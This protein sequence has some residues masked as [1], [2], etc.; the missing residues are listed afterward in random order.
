MPGWQYVLDMPTSMRIGEAFSNPDDPQPRVETPTQGSCRSALNYD[1][2]SE[3]PRDTSASPPPPP[4]P[5]PP[6][7][8]VLAAARRNLHFGQQAV[9]PH[10]QKQSNP[11]PTNKPRTPGV[12]LS[13]VLLASASQG[14]FL[15]LVFETTNDQ[16]RLV[17]KRLVVSNRRNDLKSQL[18]LYAA[19]HRAFVDTIIQALPEIEKS[20]V[21]AQVKSNLT[22]AWT[23]SQQL[24]NTIEKWQQLL[25]GDENEDLLKLEG[26]CL[27]NQQELQRH[28]MDFFPQPL[29][30]QDAPTSA[31]TPD[32]LVP[33][34]LVPAPS[35]PSS[36]TSS[37]SGS[38]VTI[39]QQYLKTIGTL[40]LL[41]DRIFNLGSD[42][43]LQKQRREG[44]RAAGRALV[45]SDKD[46]YARFRQRRLKIVN[47]YWATKREM[48]HTY[49]S[50]LDD[51]MAVQE[52]N[53]PPNL[54]EMFETEDSDYIQPRFKDDPYGLSEAS[55]N[56]TRWAQHVQKASLP[57]NIHS[58]GSKIATKDV[59]DTLQ[60]V[61]YQQTQ[62]STDLNWA[63]AS[64]GT[65]RTPQQPLSF[66]GDRPISGRRY[67][68]PMLLEKTDRDE[69][70]SALD[71]RDGITRKLERKKRELK[72]A[73]RRAS[74]DC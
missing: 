36:V 59:E 30:D 54:D 63:T 7:P 73:L 9:K 10:G 46:F 15:N 43:Q 55:M 72:L 2:M 39:M 66:L 47:D 12:P 28:V 74:S 1:Q 49:Q 38:T 27:V 22:Q 44:Y 5:P 33:N 53:L 42:L 17:Q 61:R 21:S 62:A 3:P 70:T 37:S 68:A 40:N 24:S 16:E 58:I 45:P 23:K 8:E 35:P 19:A 65:A 41:R 31:D 6:P 52:A 34:V 60:P 64:A 32:T 69:S 20:N 57:A 26:R 51:G 67:S 48:E 50:C 14:S 56:I 71:Y 11:T 4:V 13:N 25:E 18:P 29:M